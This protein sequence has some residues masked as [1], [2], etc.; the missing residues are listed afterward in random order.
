MKWQEEDRSSKEGRDF[1]LRPFT[2]RKRNG[3]SCA[4]LCM[5][6][7]TGISKARLWAGHPA[8]QEED[9]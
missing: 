7:T 9:Q 4:A 8:D 6:P 2:E 3:D 5:L 1:P